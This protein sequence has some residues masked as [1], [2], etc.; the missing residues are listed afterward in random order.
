MI[1]FLESSKGGVKVFNQKSLMMF[2]ELK[3]TSRLCITKPEEI[4]KDGSHQSIY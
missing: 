4:N 3:K 1:I 2:K